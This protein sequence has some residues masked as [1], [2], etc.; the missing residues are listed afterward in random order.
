MHASAPTSSRTCALP[1][2][3]LAQVLGDAAD[4]NGDQLSFKNAYG[5]TALPCHQ[6]LSA[7]RR[8]T[9]KCRCGAFAGALPVVPTN[10]I[11][12]PRFT[13][14]PSTNPDAYP[15]RWA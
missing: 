3:A 11:T 14:A 15:S 5:L 8:N 1:T 9:V 12:S 2:A 7:P 6:R 10:P 13:R 4:E